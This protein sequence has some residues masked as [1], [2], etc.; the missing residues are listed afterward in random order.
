MKK[1]HGKSL[2]TLFIDDSENDVEL[3]VRD[4]QRNE[5][6]TEFSR[7]DTSESLREAITT[8]PWDIILVDCSLPQLKGM[9]AIQI[10]KKQS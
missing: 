1:K 7:V 9:E 8:K 3:L 6:Y 4:L 5:Y 2:R 10:L